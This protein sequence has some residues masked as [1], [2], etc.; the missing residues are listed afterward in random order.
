[1]CGKLFPKCESPPFILIKKYIE[2]LT[3]TYSN[4][5]KQNTT[6][7]HVLILQELLSLFSLFHGALQEKTG[8]VWQG[9]IIPVKIHS[10]RKRGKD[11][12]FIVQS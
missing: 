6:S 2:N 4:S 3:S 11:C 5:L 7:S 8:E 1:M 10:L 12:L 9:N